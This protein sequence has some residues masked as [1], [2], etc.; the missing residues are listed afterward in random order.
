MRNIFLSI[1]LLLIS[2]ITYAVKCPSSADWSHDKKGD[3]VLSD[4]AKAEGWVMLFGDKSLLPTMPK[5][6]PLNAF[7]YTFGRVECLYHPGFGLVSAGHSGLADIDQLAIPPFIHDPVESTL[8]YCDTT[9]GASEVCSW[10]W[11]L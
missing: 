7:L 6:T 10:Q 9:A 4:K 8:Y 2:S 11:K 3:W 5:F 1:I